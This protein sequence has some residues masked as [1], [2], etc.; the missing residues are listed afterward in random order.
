LDRV[1]ILGQ[2]AAQANT[3]NYTIESFDEKAYNPVSSIT[4]N[5]LMGS[6]IQLVRWGTAG[7]AVLTF[8]DPNNNMPGMLY[9]I[10]DTTFVSSSRADVSE[11]SKPHELVK[12]RAVHR[13]CSLRYFQL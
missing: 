2:T 4:L 5:N 3:S 6:P 11:L 13:S 1:F 7:L 12:Q 10:Q 8:R 9:L